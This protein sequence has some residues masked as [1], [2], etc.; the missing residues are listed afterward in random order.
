MVC[1][2]KGFE[3]M[4]ATTRTNPRVAL[5]V[6]NGD[7]ARFECTY[8]RGCEGICCQQGRPPVDA[9]Q[10][11]EIDGLRERWFPL[12]R[13]EARSLVERDGWLSRRVKAGDRM[14]RVAAKWCVFFNKGCVLHTL[15]AEDGNPMGYKPEACALFPLE[16]DDK[17]NWFVRQKGFKGEEWNE[18]FCLAG[19]RET[20]LAV[21]SL[22]SEMELA[23]ELDAKKDKPVVR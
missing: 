16:K 13:P 3:F 21:N 4:P 7:T 10:Q 19:K 15:G 23:A 20:P 11:A 12:L 1:Q 9:R 6:I 2:P 5:T 18:L 8:G 22:A 17:G 14:V